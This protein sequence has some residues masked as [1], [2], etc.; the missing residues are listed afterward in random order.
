MRKESTQNS[1][2]PLPLVLTLFGPQG[3]ACKNG[4]PKNINPGEM[5]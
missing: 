3:P 2:G 5:W 4:L 1:G